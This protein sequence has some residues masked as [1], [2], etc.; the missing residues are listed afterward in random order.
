MGWEEFKNEKVCPCH[1]GTYT[2]TRQENDWGKSHVSFEMNC[3]SCQERYVQFTFRYHD[4]GAPGGT[5][6]SYLWVLKTDMQAVDAVE[7]QI[8]RKKKAVLSM[9]QV[10]YLKQW[11]ERFVDKPKKVVWAELK[12][13]DRSR[14]PSLATFYAHTKNGTPK[15]YLRTWFDAEKV[16]LILGFL[17]IH[18]SEIE[19]AYAELSEKNQ[20][21]ETLKRQMLSRGV[22][23]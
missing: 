7:E 6:S 4:P 5:S 22:H 23:I 8:K 2:I 14:V 10:R 21:I 13:I 12:A 1:N 9:A 17:G 15:A 3:T 11:L 19:E 16:I 20:K 18:D